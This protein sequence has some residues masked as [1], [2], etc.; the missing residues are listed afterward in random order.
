MDDHACDRRHEDL[1]RLPKNVAAADHKYGGGYYFRP[2]EL[3]IGGDDRDEVLKRLTAEDLLTNDEVEHL[4][5]DLYRARLRDPRSVPA[6]VAEFLA[7]AEQEAPPLVSAN[8]VLFGG[9][10]A[11]PFP[12]GPPLPWDVS[13]AAPATP[14]DGDEHGRRVTVAI[15]DSGIDPNHPWL[16]SPLVQRTDTTKVDDAESDS[17]QLRRYAGHGTHIA[18]IVRRYA[19]GATVLAHKLFG[20]DGAIDDV[21][22]A[23]ALRA[24]PKSVDVV[25]LSLG[26]YSHGDFALPATAAALG[27]YR[28]QRPSTV[29]VASAGN[30]GHT[31]P[32]WPAAF[33]HVVSVGALGPDGGKAC[34]SNFGWWVDACSGGVRVQSSFVCFSGPPEPVPSRKSCP[35]SKPVQG[36]YAGFASWSGTSFAAPKVAAAVACAI[37]DGMSGPEAVFR[38]V[39]DPGVPRLPDLGAIVEPVPIV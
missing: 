35:A 2:G 13:G 37:S 22:L 4:A 25:N 31:R 9:G 38:L 32:V 11:H 18:G 28:V 27:E 24:L 5:G 10:H 20:G 39:D 17:G 26:G 1:S 19:P 33:K 36:G 12:G 34:F 23:D 7:R 29:V 16:Q 14:P 8:H 3:L 21:A 6:V 15:L 30:D